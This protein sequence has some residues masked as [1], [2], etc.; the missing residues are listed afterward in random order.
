MGFGGILVSES[1]LLLLACS[2][3]DLML[4]ILLFLCVCTKISKAAS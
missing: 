1:L 4:H 2:N 3:G